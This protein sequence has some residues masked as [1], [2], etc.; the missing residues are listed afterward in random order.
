MPIDS[1]RCNNCRC[2]SEREKVHTCSLT[3]TLACSLCRSLYALE[4][5]CTH[6]HTHVLPLTARLVRKSTSKIEIRIGHQLTV[7][8]IAAVVGCC[9]LLSLRFDSDS[10]SRP[11]CIC[12]YSD[13]QLM[14][15]CYIF[16]F[17]FIFQIYFFNKKY[18]YIY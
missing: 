1:C 14:W 4:S 17:D 6:T 3:R 12:M 11:T 13:R 15:H 7:A 10:I 9:C 8:L 18:I 5:S 16:L 2:V